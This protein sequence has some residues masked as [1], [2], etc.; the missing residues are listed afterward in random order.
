[1]TNQRLNLT[2]LALLSLAAVFTPGCNNASAQ[3]ASSAVEN[4]PVRQVELTVYADNFGL[5]RE[6]RQVDLKQGRVKIGL[7]DVSKILDQNS[8]LFT[9]PDKT[10]AKVVS[11]T[12]D[13]GI[14]DSARLLERYLGKEV[15]LVFRG[16]NGKEGERIKGILQVAEPGNV[17][18]KAGDKFI[19]NPNAT[20]EASTGSGIVAVPQLSAEV[21]SSANAQA[22]MGVTYL[23]Q[24]LSWRADYTAT[25]SPNSDQMG[26]ECWATVTNKTGTDFPNA[27]LTFVAGSPNRAVQYGNFNGA[28]GGSSVDHPTLKAKTEMQMNTRF[29]A[30]EVMGELYAYPYKSTATIRQDQMNRVRMMGSERVMIKR[31]Y[32]IRLPYMYASG[33]Y[34]NPTQKLSATLA[35]N[36]TNSEKSGLGLP[37]PAGS[38]RVYEPDRGGNLRYIGAASIGDTQKESRVSAT[39]TEV[40][41]VY[42]NAK[43]VSA[44]R[45]NKKSVSRTAEIALYNEKSTPIELRLVQD[46]GNTYK[47]VAESEKS[48]KLSAY[49]AQW[50]V[51]LNPGEHKTLKYTVVLNG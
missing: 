9:W 15:E 7:Q 43:Q 33:Y 34:A 51:L 17:V 23:T 38:L 40:F 25:L 13:I 35:L 26:F 1:M 50:K 4:N 11:S 42:A 8:V 45:L 14:G 5:V 18:V 31:D 32:N 10:D 2:P 16:D 36:F 39:L 27:S 3:T 49:S 22:K 46:F 48:A 44:T 20:I 19:V 29:Q 47:I 12:Y 6:T 41:D 21:E 24:G 28:I 37:L 30:P